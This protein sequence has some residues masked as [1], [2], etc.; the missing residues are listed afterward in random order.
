MEHFTHPTGINM[1]KDAK[2]A[3]DMYYA[4]LVAE[5]ASMSNAEGK[6]RAREEDVG[7]LA[8]A[9]KFKGDEEMEEEEED[10][11]LAKAISLS[12]QSPSKGESSK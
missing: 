6:K 3:D 7:D 5:G 1:M 10:E 2:K 8:S 4:S 11:F 9:K 12:R